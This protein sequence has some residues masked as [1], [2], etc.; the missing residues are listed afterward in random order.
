MERHR[1]A[2][3][4]PVV[5]AGSPLLQ[6]HVA[7]ALMGISLVT[8][9]RYERANMAPPSVRYR[10]RRYYRRVAIDRWLAERGLTVDDVRQA[11]SDKS[12]CI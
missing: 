10:R 8:L 12:T 11:L 5:D 6:R 7:G 1:A 2:A 3:L 9:E 4:N